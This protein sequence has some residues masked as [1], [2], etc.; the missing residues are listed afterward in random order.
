ML[1]LPLAAPPG[2]Q[3]PLEHENRVESMQLSG[4]QYHLSPKAARAK[5]CCQCVSQSSCSICACLCI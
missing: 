4:K 3:E 1:S 5:A 2:Q